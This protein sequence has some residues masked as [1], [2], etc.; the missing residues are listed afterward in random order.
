M[1]VNHIFLY[2]KMVQV[3]FYRVQMRNE[4]FFEVSPTMDTLELVSFI[5][6]NLSDPFGYTTMAKL[7]SPC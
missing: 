4:G 6:S 7:D 5:E 3:S 2:S 1:I